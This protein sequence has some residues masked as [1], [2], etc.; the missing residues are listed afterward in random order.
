VQKP[1]QL[2]FEARM[3]LG[4]KRTPLPSRV[5]G[6]TPTRW[7]KDADKRGRQ[8][9]GANSKSKRKPLQLVLER[10]RGFA[11]SIDMRGQKE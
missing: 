3:E 9:R 8:G 6:R 4:R 11:V 7:K 1:H 5:G 2:A 10:G